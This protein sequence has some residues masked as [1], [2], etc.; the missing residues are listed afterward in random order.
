MWIDDPR[1]KERTLRSVSVSFP[2]DPRPTEAAL[3]FL[4]N[5]NA[6]TDDSLSNRNRFERDAG[7]LE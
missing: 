1:R 6:G 2:S 4:R 7:D 5:R 3:P